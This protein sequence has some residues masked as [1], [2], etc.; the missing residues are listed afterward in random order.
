MLCL[1]DCG[2]MATRQC[3]GKHRWKKSASATDLT[4]SRHASYPTCGT[5]SRNMKTE[6]NDSRLGLTR[7]HHVHMSTNQ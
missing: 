2:T 5:A 7:D 1:T 3:A 4:T 6:H